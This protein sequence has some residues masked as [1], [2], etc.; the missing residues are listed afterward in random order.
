MLIRIFILK[1]ISNKRKILTP[2]RN[3][4]SHHKTNWVVDESS[5][6][7]IKTMGS[8]ELTADK[9]LI[10]FFIYVHLLLY[11]RHMYLKKGILLYKIRNHSKPL[12]LQHNI[13]IFHKST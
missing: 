2:S 4:W 11:C 9:F 1:L 13:N 7:R 6:K 8:S 3:H 10:N 5:L 12:K